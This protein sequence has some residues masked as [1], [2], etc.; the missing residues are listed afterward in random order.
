MTRSRQCLYCEAVIACEER[1]VRATIARDTINLVM[2]FAPFCE[3]EEE[4]LRPPRCCYL[5]ACFSRVTRAIEGSPALHRATMRAWNS[6][7]R[8][9]SVLVVSVLVVM[10][11][12]PLLMDVI[13]STNARESTLV[14]AILLRC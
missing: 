8:S 2:C 1:E 12:T 5:F 9:V 6:A 13:C 11:V 14:S 3:G 4:A 7:S 10:C